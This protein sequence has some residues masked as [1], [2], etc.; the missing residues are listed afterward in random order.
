MLSSRLWI[1]MT[2]GLGLISATLCAQQPA[3][4]SRVVMPV[5]S[6]QRI[7]LHGST[8]P[9]LSGSTDQGVLP[10]STPL[11]RTLLVL[12]RSAAQEAALQALM[13]QQQLKGSPQFHQWLTPQAFG[14]QFGPSD[15]DL[16]ALTGWLS[17]SGFDG[18]HVNAGRTVVEFSGTEATLEAAFHTVLHL[19]THNGTEY[20]SNVV[21]PQ[22]PAALAP[23]LV[24]FASLND[25]PRRA[26]NQV[27][28]VFQRDTQ[29]G[30]ITQAA[31][32][33]ASSTNGEATPNFTFARGSNP[34]YGIT[35]Q[36]FAIIYDISPLWTAATP[37][38]GTGVTIAIVGETDIHPQDFTNFRTLFGLPLG[39][40]TG[41]TGSQYLNILYNGPNPGFNSNEVEADLDTQW[42]GAAAPTATIDYVASATTSTTD[43]VDLSAEYIIDN[44]LAPIMSESYGECELD[45]GTGGN[46]YINNLWQQA[47]AQ[48]ITV[49]VSTGDSGAANCDNAGAKYAVYGN[50]V[51]GLASTPWNVAVGGTDFNLPNG[52]AAYFSKT[53]SSTYE[54]ALSYIPEIPWNDSC[55][56]PALSESGAFAG[57]SPLTI[58]NLSAAS[59]DGLLTV[60][61]GG[62][63]ASSCTKSNGST[64]ASCTGGYAKPSWQSGTG[65][66]ADGVRDLPDVSLFAGNGI[67]GVFTVI[68][69]QDAN[70]DGLSCNLNSPYYDF[71]GIGGTSVAAPAFAGIMA[72]VNQKTGSRQGNANVALYDLFNQQV[73]INTSCAATGSGASS[74]FF[75]DL[76]FGSNSQPCYHGSPNC[77]IAGT[78]TYGTLSGGQTGAGYDTAS[79][80]GSVNALNLVNGWAN[81]KLLA[82]S[83]ALA[84]SPVSITHGSSVSVAVTVTAATGTPG[85]SV[86]VTGLVANGAVVSGTLNSSGDFNTKVLNFP[87]GTY[88][89]T[90]YYAGSA[91]Y[92]PSDSPAVTLVVNP[93]PSIEAVVPMLDNYATGAISNVSSPVI[94]GSVNF[95]RLS[96]TGAS[97]QG[98]ATGDL[99]VTDNGQP[100]DGGVFPLTS[101]GNVED[102][103]PSLTAGTHNYVAT[104]AGDASFD[105]GSSHSQL[106]ITPAATTTVFQTLTDS[107]T[108]SGLVVLPVTI[109]TTG[110]GY[111]SPTGTVT[112][113]KGT[114][115]LGT[116]VVGPS[117]APTDF[118]TGSAVVSFPATELPTGNTL[119][120]ATYSGDTN[121]TGSS[122]TTSATVTIAPATTT[123]TFITLLLSPVNLPRGGIL[124]MTATVTPVSP[125]PTGLVYFYVDGQYAGQGLLSRGTTSLSQAITLAI[126]QH[127]VTAAYQG[128][129]N[130]SVSTATGNF[131][132]VGATTP[133]SVSI[134]L[135]QNT[136]TVGQTITVTGNV[137]PAAATGTLQLIM[138]GNRY[139]PPVTMTGGSALLPLTTSTLVAGA[140]TVA[141]AYSGDN[142]YEASESAVLP[143]TL[144]ATSMGSFTLME[145]NTA[146]TVTRGTTSAV[147]TL[148]LTPLGGFDSVVTFACTGLPSGASCIFAPASLTLNGSATNA[149]LSF[150]AATPTA[151]GA[152]TRPTQLFHR[153]VPSLF[154]LLVLCLLPRRRMRYVLL[155]LLL[156]TLNLLSACGG[157]QN[158]TTTPSGG[159]PTGTYNIVVIALSTPA[160]ITSNITLTVK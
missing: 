27:A 152:A 134:A 143:F 116:A 142:T 147:T 13:A 97:G 51:N 59:S 117:S 68:C 148:T 62:G 78:D 121:Y 150:T 157:S 45:I 136:V 96:V 50:A 126:G 84:L 2:F 120:T 18:I 21:D 38:Q 90:A 9:L 56:N 1:G 124:T 154:A 40:T 105:A 4:V 139:N 55:A 87:G 72:L 75:H 14:E 43:G 81:A 95:L 115:V 61:G 98:S 74:C 104:Y 49:L 159:T 93:E 140:H 31:T 24:G 73:A 35:P 109:N 89:V 99:L 47:A 144:T 137:L 146:I 33:S 53:N 69:Q 32:A 54:S 83:T 155:P 101:A 66:P 63:G 138:D 103:S 127:T 64:V 85:G 145:N 133:S 88:N 15:A 80:L 6:A 94:Y 77:V 102:F 25:V 57:D 92:A 112:I 153:G 12:Q 46:T 26:Y 8:R 41:L 100:L 114:T 20:T 7:T 130:Y 132:I 52:G 48:G 28:G 108:A 128:D 70:A 37:I 30:A 118:D 79:G 107:T 19:Y 10:S 42:A 23:I 122:T 113:L 11:L 76:T 110:F 5:D 65:V 156:L 29:T 39:N 158:S 60:V 17:R 129:A 22:I 149:A 131:N 123:P 111:Q 71:V 36:D 160:T 44:N 125:S 119:V 58:C 106:I 151:A 16:A 67:Y 135:S 141:I 3:V 82:T 91:T 34:Y 86:S